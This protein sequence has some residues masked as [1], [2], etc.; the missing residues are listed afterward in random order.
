MLEMASAT[1]R[2]G[3]V[4]AEERRARRRAALLDA[5]LDLFAEAG[6]GA[7]TKRAVCARARLND[8][9]FYELFTDSDALLEA[10]A[11]EFTADIL[12]MVVPATLAAGPGVR[13]QVH[14]AATAVIDFITA[15]PRRAHF[16]LSSHSSDVLQR[17]RLASTHQ[18]AQVM[19]A[20]SRELLG[21][22]VASPEDTGL[23]AF[24]LVS[25]TMEL[26]AAWLRGEF[27]TSRD[28]LI[29]VITAMLLAATDLST[30]L[31]TTASTE[32]E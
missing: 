5:A 9:Y 20:M 7:V 6:A 30:N 16:L 28:H 12:N 27:P 18:V 11:Q 17:A 25:G 10:M 31:P 15:D 3:G 32:A 21:D 19:A 1:R 13:R 14:A 29:D 22:A 23:A 24:T 26:V 8:R 2:Y 4:S